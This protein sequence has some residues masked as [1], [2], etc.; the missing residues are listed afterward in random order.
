MV[1]LAGCAVWYK[2]RKPVV[3]I[4]IMT[5]QS[6]VVNFVA[7]NVI[8][9][10]TSFQMWKQIDSACVWCQEHQNTPVV[11]FDFDL[12]FHSIYSQ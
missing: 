10:L 5:N 4:D 3:S 12:L 9:G 7:R 8:Y 2:W 6:N 1:S 11:I